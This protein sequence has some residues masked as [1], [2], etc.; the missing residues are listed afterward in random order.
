MKYLKILYLQNL[1]TSFSSE[2]LDM[3]LNF[4]KFTL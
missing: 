1:D 3:Y 2:T 4:I